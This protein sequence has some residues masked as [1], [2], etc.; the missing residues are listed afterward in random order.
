MRRNEEERGKRKWRRVEEDCEGWEGAGGWR[1][2]EEGGGGWRRV[3]G[4]GG[5]RR[6]E[7]SGGR[8]RVEE[9]G[10]GWRK[11]EEGGGGWREE[12]GGR[13][14]RADLTGCQGYHRMINLVSYALAILRD[15]SNSLQSVLPPPP[16]S[17]L[18]FPPSVMCLILLVRE[19]SE[20]NLLVHRCA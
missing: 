9:G 18:S 6:A 17:L 3:E 7:E 10:G 1:R 13:G 2:V 16:S 14:W 11:V 19:V 5:R 15:S 12:E 20:C 4:R 8:R